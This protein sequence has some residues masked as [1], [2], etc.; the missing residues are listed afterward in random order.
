MLI[1]TSSRPVCMTKTLTI[2]GFTQFSTKIMI[3]RYNSVKPVKPA[4]KRTYQNYGRTMVF[5]AENTRDVP[6]L[7]V[8]SLFLQSQIVPRWRI[9][10]L[11]HLGT[12]EQSATSLIVDAGNKGNKGDSVLFIRIK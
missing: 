4:T 5:S 9:R 11:R 7:S 10:V 2:D 6:Y 8:A 12:G 1:H 3:I